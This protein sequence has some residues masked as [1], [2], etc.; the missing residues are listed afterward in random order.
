MS[1]DQKLIDVGNE[2]ANAIDDVLREVCGE[3]RGFILLICGNGPNQGA[4]PGHIFS[5]IEPDSIKDLLASLAVDP[6]IDP[7][8][9]TR[10]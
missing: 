1:N 2:A 9:T 6:C 4:G 5:N 10:H 3:E 7:D 8:A